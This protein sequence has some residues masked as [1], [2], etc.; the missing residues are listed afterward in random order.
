MIKRNGK[1]CLQDAQCDNAPIK[2]DVMG[3]F[4]SET[5]ELKVKAIVATMG[6]HIIN[7]L[8][9][10]ITPLIDQNPD[11]IEIEKILI[12]PIAWKR[13]LP[14]THAILFCAILKEYGIR[15]FLATL[16]KV[17]YNS[18]KTQLKKLKS[19]YLLQSL[20]KFINIKRDF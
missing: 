11:A 20:D 5:L 18:V 3:T 15:E 19:F 12:E 8:I 2:P 17:K 13:A 16:N 4:A 9:E 14:N 6:P 10:K 7:V 1:K